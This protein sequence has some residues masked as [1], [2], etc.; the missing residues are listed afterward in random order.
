M[1]LSDKSKLKEQTNGE[2]NIWSIFHKFSRLVLV[3][4]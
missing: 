1:E 2:S 3:T 4:Q